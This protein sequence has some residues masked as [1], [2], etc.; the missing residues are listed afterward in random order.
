MRQSSVIKT[1][2][3]NR[4]RFKPSTSR[5]HR[6]L[7]KHRSRGQ[8]GGMRNKAKAAKAAK[9]A[10]P[11][12]DYETKDQKN[13][14]IKREKEAEKA[15]I[16]R[17]KARI[18]R[19]KEAE[20]ALKK[21]AKDATKDPPS[22]NE[23]LVPKTDQANTDKVKTDQAS[24][25]FLETFGQN[26]DFLTQKAATSALVAAEAAE[27]AEA[28]AAEA[29]AAEAAAAAWVV[30]ENDP[31]AA[32]NTIFITVERNN[33][34]PL[35]HLQV[36]ECIVDPAGILFMMA[37]DPKYVTFYNTYGTK[38]GKNVGANGLSRVIY[39]FINT[40]TIPEAVKTV[41]ITE[42]AIGHYK[43]L[44]SVIHARGPNG[45]NNRDTF[46]HQPDEQPFIKELVATYKNI[47][48]S[49]FSENMIDINTV[50]VYPIS[51][52]IY[53]PPQLRKPLPI[54]GNHELYVAVTWYALHKGRIEAMKQMVEEDASK[55]QQLKNINIKLYLNVG[56]GDYSFAE[57][58]L[59]PTVPAVDPLDL[60]GM[61]TRE[62]YH[63]KQ[64]FKSQDQI[65]TG[66]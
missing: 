56:S 19:E 1:R 44:G 49:C 61:L 28:A 41:E 38:D 3:R 15:R 30:A 9:A 31:I 64:F 6:L 33:R 58:V 17:E 36:N 53:S 13:A 20:K 55:I 4:K 59:M 35:A 7:T 66:E 50:I 29:A 25:N 65:A 12:S 45:T 51:A 34:D 47:F 57:Q 37:N 5:K 27:A 10:S 48:L 52:G 26:S 14:R 2:K 8:M 60:N 46:D 63:S 23:P 18:K 39:T 16:K 40:E 22:L 54:G 32:Q 24:S 42:N 21:E 43:N 62:L 11:G